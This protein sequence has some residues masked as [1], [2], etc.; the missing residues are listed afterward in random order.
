MTL[1]LT[2]AFEKTYPGGASVRAELRCP[3]AGFSITALFGPSGCGKTTVLRCLAGLERPDR[4][5]IHFAD[6]V[7]FDAQ[8]RIERRP[9]ARD[10]G[11]LFQEYALFPHLTVAANVAYGLYT[12]P[13]AERM[14]RVAEVLERFEL[15]GLDARYPWQISGGQQ[16]RVALARAIAP[17]AVATA[18]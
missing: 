4:G 7:W 11:F 12:L 18:R 8:E 1:E 10:I 9:Q 6:E 14:R 16:Q 2:A 13:A 15:S 5:H 3:A 17:A